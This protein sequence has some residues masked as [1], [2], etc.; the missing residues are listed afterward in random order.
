[1]ASWDGFSIRL[2]GLKIRPTTS[3]DALMKAILIW[4]P[5]LALPPALSAGY[6]FGMEQARMAGPGRPTGQSHDSNL[7][8]A[9][10]AFEQATRL[11]NQARQA[12]PGKERD[13][14]RQAV[15]Q[16]RVCLAYESAT[17]AP[18]RLFDEA[19]HNL[20][21]TRLLLEQSQQPLQEASRGRQPPESRLQP[22]TPGADAPGSPPAA[23]EPAVS[24]PRPQ[25]AE[26][27]WVA[28]AR[29]AGLADQ[30][31][32]SAKP[33]PGLDA[34]ESDTGKLI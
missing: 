7:H 25:P 10:S 21:A 28:A 16:Y 31:A 13:L 34:G 1:M 32:A 29:Q 19:R 4:L 11:L 9:Q 12:S 20:E 27:R 23:P 6:Y 17:T 30:G 15:V 5:L 2:D 24:K 18:A 8:S 3:G 33:G 22:K 26:R 14:L